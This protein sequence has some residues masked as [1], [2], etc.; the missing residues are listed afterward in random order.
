MKLYPRFLLTTIAIAV[1]VTV[2]LAFFY[3]LLTEQSYVETQ[4]NFVLT[5]MQSGG[6]ESCQASPQTWGQ[7]VRGGPWPGPLRR[8]EPRPGDHPPP[9][10]PGFSHPGPGQRPPSGEGFAPKPADLPPPPPGEAGADGPPPG[11]PRDNQGPPPKPPWGDGHRPPPHGWMFA[12]NLELQSSNPQAPTLPATLRARALPWPR[13]R[14]YVTDTEGGQ[15]RV[16]VHMPWKDGPCTLVLVQLPAMQSPLREVPLTLWL[17]PVAA[18]FL[19]LLLSLGP[20]VGRIR[21]LTRAVRATQGGPVK[22]VIDVGGGD[23]IGELATAFTEAGAEIQRRIEVQE[24]RETFLRNFLENTTHDVMTPL[25]V[26]Q[27]HISTLADD[28]GQDRPETRELLASAMNETQYMRSLIH[29]LSATAALEGMTP[30]MQW[31]EVDLAAVVERVVLRHRPIARP[32]DISIDFAVPENGLLTMGDVTF[33]EQAIDN[34]VGNA[35]RYHNPGGHV[36]LI[37]EHDPPERFVLKVVDDGPGMGRQEMSRLVERHFR[38]EE[39]RTRA[40]N[41]R[42]LGLNI[43]YH[44]AQLHQ[45]TF[46]MGPSEFGGVEVVFTGRAGTGYGPPG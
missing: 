26:L 31:G 30:H 38:G 33:I 42:G 41:G 6:R 29:N 20:V 14:G 39:A 34:V 17:I 37:L 4:V 24:Q 25:T 32:R 40:P 13:D 28:A 45:W 8:R 16:M 18:V 5:Y 12:Y 2:G 43:T 15:T 9:W 46:D 36:A 21:R 7:E 19:A 1:P 10:E 23:E 27:G 35:V 11:P 22:P 3:T 44:L